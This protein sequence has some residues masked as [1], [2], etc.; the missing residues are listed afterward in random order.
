VRLAEIDVRIIEGASLEM[1]LAEIDENLCRSDLT[2]AQRAAAVKR[3][4]TIWDNL[5]GTEEEPVE[6]E[7]EVGKVFPPQLDQDVSTMSRPQ[8]KE[9]AAATADLTGE[10]KRAINQQ[11]A[12]ATALEDDLPKIVGTSLDKGVELDALAKLPEPERK[13]LIERAAKGEKVSAKTAQDKPKTASRKLLALAEELADPSLTK[14][15]MQE[16]NEPTDKQISRILQVEKGLRNIRA[17][18]DM[19]EGE[20]II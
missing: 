17:I 18:V 5:G 4:K 19:L 3:R 16:L 8:K 13:D 10:T 12:R 6:P 9:F 2:A 7:L 20:R 11:L 1:E 14:E 15:T